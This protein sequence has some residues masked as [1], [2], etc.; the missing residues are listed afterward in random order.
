VARALVA[1]C[2]TRLALDAKDSTPVQARL[3]VAREAYTELFGIDPDNNLE[4]KALAQLESDV[5]AEGR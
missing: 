5:R 3:K 2:R 4:R 1:A